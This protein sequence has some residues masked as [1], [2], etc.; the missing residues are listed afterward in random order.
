LRQAREDDKNKAIVLRVNSPGGD[1][2]ASELIRREVELTKAAHKPIVVSMG[3]VAASGG[4]WIS[5]NGDRIFAQPTT[6]TGSIGIFGL[7][8]NI[9]NTLAKIGVHTDGVGTT[10]LAD[11]LDPRRPLDPKVGDVLQSLINKGYQDFIGKV[12]AARHKP[13]NEIDAIARGRVWSGEQALQRGLVDEL[14]GL[15]DALTAAAQAANLGT[16]FR[17]HYVEKPLSAWERFALNLSSDGVAHVA[18]ALLP[19]MPIG[20]INQPDIR[21]QLRLLQSLGSG[22]PGVFAYCF[23][24]LR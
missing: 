2:F 4:Y 15:G 16:N 13:E 24:D 7:F 21:S 20:L 17:V 8:M 19:Q 11:A 10:P 9:P 18:H 23:C 12:S 5:M 6:I 14:G 22:K 1:A 3:D